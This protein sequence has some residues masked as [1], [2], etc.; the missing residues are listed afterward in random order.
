MKH[1]HRSHASSLKVMD[2]DMDHRLD[3]AQPHFMTL[4]A[5]AG[6]AILS[7][8][9]NNYAAPSEKLPEW[10]APRPD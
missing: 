4:T 6:R 3:L 2:V 1:D 8:M 10:A 9:A 7:D 5:N